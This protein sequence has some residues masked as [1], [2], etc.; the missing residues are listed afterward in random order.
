LVFVLLHQRFAKHN[1]LFNRFLQLA[2]FLILIESVHGFYFSLKTAFKFKSHQKEI[3]AST[4]DAI[5]SDLTELRKYYPGK[6]VELVAENHSLRWVGYLYGNKVYCNTPALAASPDLIPPDTVLLVAI[7][8]DD[9]PFMK[10]YTSNPDVRFI[11]KR[12]GFYLFI[13]DR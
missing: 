2:F 8:E 5:L 6:Q 12:G 11:G 4:N 13:Q 1:V 9:F 7:Q 3:F 10:N